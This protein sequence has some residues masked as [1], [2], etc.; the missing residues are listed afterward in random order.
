MPR[1]QR[2]FERVGFTVLPYPVDFQSSGFWAGNP[3]HNPLNFLPNANGLDRSS[4]ALR[5]AIGRTI[6]RSW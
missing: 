1:A 4:H 2:L 5:E 6:Y 3:L